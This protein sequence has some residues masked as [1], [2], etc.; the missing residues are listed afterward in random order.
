MTVFRVN[1]ICGILVT[2][3]SVQYVVFRSLFVSSKTHLKVSRGPPIQSHQT[4][5]QDGG[6]PDDVVSGLQGED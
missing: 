3:M 4:I 5:W 2:R 6:S 1:V